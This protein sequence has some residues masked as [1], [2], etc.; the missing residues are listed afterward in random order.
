MGD[1]ADYIIENGM[2]ASWAGEDWSD[3]DGVTCR[4]CRRSGFEWVK[5]DKGWR[6]ETPTGRAHT[7][8]AYEKYRKR[9]SR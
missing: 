7:C 2:M 1:M 5:T 8:K 9:V 6:L 4:Y 3:E